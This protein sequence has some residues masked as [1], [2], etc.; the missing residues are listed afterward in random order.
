MLAAMA[1]ETKGFMGGSMKFGV[2]EELS[3]D[4]KERGPLLPLRFLVVTDL[5]PR[6]PY[7]AGASAPEGV[8][9]VDPASFDDLFTRLRPRLAIDVPCVLTEGQWMRIDL[10]PTSLKSFRP[11]GLLAEVPLLRALLDGRMVLERLRDGQVSQEQAQQELHRLWSGSPFVREILGLLPS[12]GPA[13]STAASK[14]APATAPAAPANAPSV[15]SLLDMVDLSTPTSATPD[16]PREAP[17]PPVQASVSKFADLIATVARAGKTSTGVRPTEAVSRVEKAIGAQ[18]GAILQHPEVRR[19][20]QAYRGLRFIT[21]RAQSHTGVRFDVINARP[22]DMADAFVRAIRANASSE[23]PVS[24]AIVELTVDGSAVGFSRLEA[25]ANVAESHNVPVLVNG[26]PRLLGVAD[27]AGVEAL[28]NKGALFAAPQQAP[29]RA[30]AAK[31]QLRW[32][33]I[34][35]NG[36][37][38]RGPYDK[39]TSRVREAVVKELP[40]DEGAWVYLAPAYAVAALVLQS[41]RETGWPCRVLGAKSGGIIENL[42]VR[43]LAS[44][45]GGHPHTPGEHDGAEGI[46]VPTEVFLSTDTQRELGKSGVLALASAPNSDAAYVLTAPTAYVTPPKRTYDSATTEPEVRLERVSLGDQLFVARLVQFL[47]ALCGK[48]P[49]TI[50]A[51]EAQELVQGALWALFE[52]AKPGTIELAAKGARGEEGTVVQ[53]MVRPRR[54]LG[55]QIEEIALEMPLG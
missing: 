45:D 33:S 52:D 14:A 26:S 25:V 32:A 42:P 20:E 47:R 18:I 21:E 28:D 23:P 15:D 7:N 9:R 19:L 29:W 5:V 24:C 40:D 1:G 38:A 41:F 16:V 12:A 3:A 30:V 36:V 10:S 46:A 2:G 37:L 17:P 8:L 49:P 35:L 34:A 50:D 54:F 55:V 27:L 22:D 11:D 13:A 4:E 44:H 31:P 39:N 6:D 48:L 51:A 43:Q 53:V